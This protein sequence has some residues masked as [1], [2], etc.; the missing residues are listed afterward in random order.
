MPK[1]AKKTE[2]KIVKKTENKTDARKKFILG[3]SDDP[4]VRPEITPELYTEFDFSRIFV[5]PIVNS[6]FKSGNETN[7]S[8]IYY[9]N[10]DDE[11]C[12][13]YFFGPSAQC[14]A[15]S[16][17]YPYSKE[18]VKKDAEGKPIKRDPKERRG[19]QIG[20]PLTGLTTVEEPSDLEAAWMY[21]LDGLR[22]RIAEETIKKR[23]KGSLD[24]NMPEVCCALVDSVKIRDRDGGETVEE[25]NER[26]L[27][28]VKPLITQGKEDK[29]GNL[30]PS[31]FYVPLLT[32]GQGKE[33]TC[34][35][36]FF[37][38][39]QAEGWNPME[40]TTDFG[41][42]TVSRGSLDLPLY[43]LIDMWWGA[44]GKKP[45]ATSMKIVLFQADWTILESN[46][47]AS[48]PQ[49]RVFGGDLTQW[50]APTREQE[51]FPDDSASDGEDDGKKKKSSKPKAKV[52]PKKAKKVTEE[53]EEES[54]EEDVKVV[55]KKKPVPKKKSKKVISE[56]EEEEEEEP[57]K[58]SKAKSK[59]K[60]AKV[61][62]EEE[63]DG[64]D[65]DEDE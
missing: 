44:H 53:E 29:E 10:D 36:V 5:E 47:N 6:K 25:Y 60:P 39:D 31:T 65:E 27:G 14:F 48:V 19:I 46:K 32:R 33:L 51:A 59:K 63:E 37:H 1:T 22:L 16:Y 38:Q 54:S 2:T 43:Y 58:K 18:E 45:Y 56:E 13:F 62:E 7:R 3:A 50:S 55:P 30:R 28:C 8:E 9:L 34:Q 57:P 20:V 40:V 23:V 12:D 49:Q 64:E 26:K 15:P 61:I 24:K 21:F 4:T 11:K 52:L 42:G 35:T 17:N 41:D